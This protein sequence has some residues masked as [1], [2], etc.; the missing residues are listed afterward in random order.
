MVTPESVDSA[1]INALAAGQR[2]RVGGAER[3]CVGERHRG[4]PRG[5][6]PN[7]PWPCC[8]QRSFA[9]HRTLTALEHVRALRELGGQAPEPEVE[10]RPLTRYDALIPA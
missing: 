1:A 7:L 10:T 4:S 2:H 8:H 9:R 3:R 6:A 5:V